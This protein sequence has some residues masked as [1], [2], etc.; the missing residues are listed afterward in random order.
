MMDK[1]SLDQSVLDL[2]FL[3]RVTAGMGGGLGGPGPGGGPP[4]KS[5]KKTNLVPGTPAQRECAGKVAG[6]IGFGFVAGGPEGAILGGG[7]TAADCVIEN[8]DAIAKSGK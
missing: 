4:R 5:P 7:A 3:A 2:E 8:W 1:H 6:G